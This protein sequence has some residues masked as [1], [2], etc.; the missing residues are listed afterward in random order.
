MDMKKNLAFVVSMAAASFA[1]NVQ[2][3]APSGADF[4][5]DAPQIVNSLVRAAVSQSGNTPVEDSTE[6]QLR[7]NIMTMGT[8]YIVVCEQTK[9][10]AVV[11]SGKQKA[12]SVDAL[13][14]AIEQAVLSALG[15]SKPEAPAE[16]AP[17]PEPVAPEPE[18]VAEQAAAPAAD[19]TADSTTA[20]KKEPLPVNTSVITVEVEE[21]P[22][23]KKEEPIGE[24]R[25]TRNYSSF[26]L[27]AALWH[28]YDYSAKESDIKS[29]D[30]KNVERSWKATFALHYA[31]IF[32]VSTHAAITMVNNGNFVIGKGWE[33]HDVFLIGARY[34]T[35]ASAIS[36]FFGGGF[37]IGGQF[38][39]HY[40]KIDEFLA[41]GLAGGLEAG[42]VLF[43]NS[44]LQ[45]EL[46]VTWDALWDEFNGFGRRFGSGTV[47]L[48][49][50][51]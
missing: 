46:G 5:P 3:V 51:Y 12:T 26:G 16:P 15:E 35:S 33:V 1:A 7:T 28:N 30:D 48:A 11:G 13:D 38:D 37:G 4:S 6:I 18:P 25:P 34:Y 14:T 27:G 29:G 44:A 42:I 23:E 8:S 47:Y 31:M 50:N 9:S 20:Q 45:L 40:E 49:V 22:V 2:V 39:N 24:K 41:I 43:R 32:E 36:P 21:A 19:S 10:G 17:E